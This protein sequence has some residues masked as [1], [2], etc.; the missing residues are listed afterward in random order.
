MV[1]NRSI[2]EKITKRLDKESFSASII[3]IVRRQ[4]I[5]IR[6]NTEAR[7]QGLRENLIDKITPSGMK[8]GKHLVHK[9]C[10]KPPTRSCISYRSWNVR[11]LANVVN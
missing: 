11:Q 9:S 2:S 1:L 6:Q 7:N 5:G 3:L 4:S 10:E 8:G